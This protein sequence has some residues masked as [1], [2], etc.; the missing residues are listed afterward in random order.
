MDDNNVFILIKLLIDSYRHFNKY[1]YIV[2]Y[3]CL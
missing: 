3:C 1:V 2:L